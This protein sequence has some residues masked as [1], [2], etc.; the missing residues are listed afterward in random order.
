M[1]RF[2]RTYEDLALK[3]VFVSQL[4][5]GRTGG[6]VTQLQLRLLVDPRTAQQLMDTL[7]DIGYVTTFY[8]PDGDEDTPFITHIGIHEITREGHRRLQALSDEAFGRMREVEYDFDNYDFREMT[9]AIFRDFRKTSMI[10]RHLRQ[11]ASSGTA[12][13][14]ARYTG[15]SASCKMTRLLLRAESSSRTISYELLD[16]I[17][18]SLG[19][20]LAGVC[21]ERR[22]AVWE[23]IVTLSAYLG[24][25]T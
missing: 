18:H 12:E 6:D 2:T 3:A 17:M 14:R 20:A 9:D 25:A 11:A 23:E 8:E 1:P 7:H 5:E 19:A 22:Q 24:L 13:D 16:E 4:A 21:P 10:M 15:A